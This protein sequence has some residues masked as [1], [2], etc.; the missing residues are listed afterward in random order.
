MIY[1]LPLPQIVAV[2]SGDLLAYYGTT[3]GIIGSFITY[4]YETNK[5][6][7]EKIK[8]LQPTFV[9]SVELVNEEANVFSVDIINLSQK[10]LTFFI[11]M[12]NLYRLSLKRGILLRQHL[13]KLSKKQNVLIR[14]ITSLWIRI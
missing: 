5:N 8:E 11:F 12:I 6:K 14:T 13:I 9:V 7:K 10:T 4:R 1:A 2:E 3:F